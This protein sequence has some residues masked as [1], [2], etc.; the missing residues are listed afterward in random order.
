MSQLAHDLLAHDRRALARA[1]TLVEST[2][3]DH[4]NESDE[5]LAEIIAHTG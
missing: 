1:I 4:R 2:R 5:L 3:T